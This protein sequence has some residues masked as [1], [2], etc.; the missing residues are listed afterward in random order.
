M[1]KILAIF[2]AALMLGFSGCAS[3][4]A[5]PEKSLSGEPKGQKVP[6]YYYAAFAEADALKE[7]LGAAGFEIVATYAPTKNSETIV[8]TTE[9]LKAAASKPE[10]GFAA[11]LRVLVDEENNRVSVTN[12]VYF[13]KAF[14]QGAYD[15]KLATQLNESLAS[16]LGEMTAAPDTL[17]YD[18]L[19]GYHF[20]V[21]MPYYDDVYELGEGETAE[22][23]SKLESYKKGKLVEF[24]LALG[25]G[26]TL[27]GVDLS[28]R[29]KK[30]VSKI[31]AQNAQILPYTVLIED[32]KAKALA[33]KYYIAISYPLLS[34]GEFMT[35]ATVPGAIEKELSKPFK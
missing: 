19:D 3:K 5:A 10:R 15:H 25:E 20:M 4:A 11:I 13:G 28:R 29:T 35:I 1:R 31:G 7:K 2:A 24:K 18:E 6:A 30:F 12:P 8:I 9:A 26:R 34:M 22:L 23:A 17:E 32:G 16:V 33:G 14:L 27:Y 21:G